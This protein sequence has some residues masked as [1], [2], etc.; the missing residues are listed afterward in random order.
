MFSNLQLEWLREEDVCCLC[1]SFAAMVVN[2]DVNPP[3]VFPFVD[4]KII[5]ILNGVEVGRASRSLICTA[6]LTLKAL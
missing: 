3:S 6:T 1:S 2:H 5:L 4:G